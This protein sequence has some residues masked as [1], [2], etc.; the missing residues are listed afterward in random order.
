MFVA[1]MV[2][3]FTED[4]ESSLGFYRGLLGF[5][6]TFRAPLEGV[7]EH[8]ELALDGFMI[9]LSTTEAARRAHCIDAKPGSAAMELVFWTENLDD[10]YKML[11]AA[12]VPSVREPQDSGNNNRNALVRDPDGNLVVVVA[13]RS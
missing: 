1:P 11:L 8:V 5:V 10:A 7:P 6:E 13:K 9:A 12:N 4:I 2:N 3:L